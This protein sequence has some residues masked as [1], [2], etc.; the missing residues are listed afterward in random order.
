MAQL[1]NI[2]SGKINFD[3]TKLINKKIGFL[4]V[5]NSRLFF[6]NDKLIL[7]TNILIDIHNSD[8]LFSLF[9]TPRKA[10]KAVNKIF[11]NLDYDL[12]MDQVDINNITIDSVESNNKMLSVISEFNNSND[13]NLNKSRRIFNKLFSAYSG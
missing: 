3:K 6:E 5:D 2:I 10:R 13:Y 7:N 11:I 4:E 9:Q 1:F 12:L 8:N